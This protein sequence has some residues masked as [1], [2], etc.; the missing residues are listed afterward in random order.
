MVCPI[1]RGT[2]PPIVLNGHVDAAVDEKLHGFV[3]LAEDQLVQDACW[4]V[5]APSRIDIGAVLEQKV[6]YVEVIRQTV[7]RA[8]V[9]G[10]L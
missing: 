5:R 2:A 6:G 9:E 4:L 10:R 1:L 8:D 3:I 7:R